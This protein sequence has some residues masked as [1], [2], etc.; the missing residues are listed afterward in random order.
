[1]KNILIVCALTFA[2]CG[3]GP[4]KTDTTTT[5]TTTTTDGS[6]AGS[7]ATGDGQPCTQ[8]VAMVCP[9]G[10]IDGCL[11]TPAEGTNHACVAK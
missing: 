11:K 7:A 8:E 4:K 10:Q 9:D 3:G 5:T 6:G 2:A 1:M